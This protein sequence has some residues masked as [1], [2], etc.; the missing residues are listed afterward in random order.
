MKVTENINTDYYKFTNNFKKNIRKKVQSRIINNYKTKYREIEKARNDAITDLKTSLNAILQSLKPK[1]TL[2]NKW[3][4]K[5]ARFNK[6]DALDKLIDEKLGER[7][8]DL[9]EVGSDLYLATRQMQLQQFQELEK[10]RSDG[11]SGLKQIKTT[12]G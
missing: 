1:I 6:L 8:S 4:N 11:F 2:N 3:S 7:T 12:T 9:D 5:K 10:A